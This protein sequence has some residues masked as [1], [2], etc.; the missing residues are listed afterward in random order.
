MNPLNEKGMILFEMLL[1]L[2][3]AAVLVL[4]PTI[5]TNETK[6]QLDNQ[7]FI[8]EFQSQ[9]TAIQNYAVL[10]GQVTMM[11]VSSQYKTVQ[12]KVIGDEKN[13]LNKLI[14]LPET[15]TTPT[16]KTYYFN[17]YTGNLRNFDTLVF[18]INKQRHT[19]TFQ[20]GSGRYKWQ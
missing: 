3:V 17:G 2:F 19:M 1:V 15:I 16:Y 6:N 10:S 8:E 12:F 11:T 14:Y 20:L 18:F 13:I 5:Y 9:M 4:I 7:L